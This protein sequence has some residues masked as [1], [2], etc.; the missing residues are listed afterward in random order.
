MKFNQIGIAAV[1]IIVIILV[2]ISAISVYFSLTKKASP[3]PLSTPVPLPSILKFSP[4]PSVDTSKLIPLPDLSKALSGPQ[5]EFKHEGLPFTFS[6]P[7]YFEKRVTN[8]ETR[9]AEILKNDPGY[10]WRL[11]NQVSIQVPLDSTQYNYSEKCGDNVVRIFV[12]RYGNLDNTGLYDFIKT[13][14]AK[15]PGDGITETSDTYKKGLI[16]IDYPKSGSYQFKGIISE[17]LAKV[18]YF[19]YGDSFYSFSLSGGCNTGEGYS[20]AAEE[21]FD[22]ILRNI[23]FN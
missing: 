14:N 7:A 12:S 19:E 11:L 18:V 5:T 6:Y 20:E 13:L 21:I 17:N 16:Q 9:K 8:V 2:M 3:A 4:L 22:T 15:Y 23:K 1:T 10:I